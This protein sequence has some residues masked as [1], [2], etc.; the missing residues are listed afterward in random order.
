MGRPELPQLKAG[1]TSHVPPG[2]VRRPETSPG[3]FRHLGGQRL[4]LQDEGSV[5][6]WGWACGLTPGVHNDL[7]MWDVIKF[8]NRK[9]EH[10]RDSEVDVQYSLLEGFKNKALFFFGG[11]RWTGEVKR[12]NEPLPCTKPSEPL[13]STV[14]PTGPLE[15]LILPGRTVG[16]L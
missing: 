12:R 7:G 14:N 5:G 13:H 4:Q 11:T 8:G 15:Q 2:P 1:P 10:P 9:K 3:G 6:V 16:R